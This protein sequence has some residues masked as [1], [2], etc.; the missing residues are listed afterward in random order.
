LLLLLLLLLLHVLGT[1][2]WCLANLWTV[3]VAATTLV[4]SVALSFA[5]QLVP[6]VPM[7]SHDRQV[8]VLVLADEVLSCADREPAHL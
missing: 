1:G 3:T 4:H 6:Q 8:D 5:E 7:D 2:F